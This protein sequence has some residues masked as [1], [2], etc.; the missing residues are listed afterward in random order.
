MTPRENDADASSIVHN[1]RNATPL[2][3]D[4]YHPLWDYLPKDIQAEEEK[5]E[6]HKA[7]LLGELQKLQQRT[8]QR[9]ESIAIWREQ[10]LRYTPEDMLGDREWQNY[11][12]AIKHTNDPLIGNNPLGKAPER[13]PQEQLILATGLLRG[14]LSKAQISQLTERAQRLICSMDPMNA[15]FLTGEDLKNALKQ[16]GLTSKEAINRTL[17]RKATTYCKQ[18]DQREA[19]RTRWETRDRL[20]LQTAGAQTGDWG[21]DETEVLWACT[22]R[23]LDSITKPMH[24]REW[25]TPQGYASEDLKLGIWGILREAQDRGNIDDY[26]IDP[27]EETH[28]DALRECLEDLSNQPLDEWHYAVQDGEHPGQAWIRET[29]MVLL[30]GGNTEEWWKDMPNATPENKI[31][32]AIENYRTTTLRDARTDANGSVKETW[33]M[34]NKCMDASTLRAIMKNPRAIQ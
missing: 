3:I 26:T 9:Q 30:Y 20:A 34:A 11:Y 10:N 15:T 2:A 12:P 16:E 1:E 5:A 25:W 32:Q 23:I 29:G 14:T 22:I 6:K 17:N 28:M 19:L 4:R 31:D 13:D 24:G 27:R 18:E 33:D 8:I 7:Y 21:E